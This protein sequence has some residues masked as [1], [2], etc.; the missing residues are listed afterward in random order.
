MVKNVR[1][2]IDEEKFEEAADVILQTLAT[3]INTHAVMISV[4][5]KDLLAIGPALISML[6]GSSESDDE[7]E[8]AE[9]PEKTDA[10]GDDI[11]ITPSTGTLTITY[12]APEGDYD[13]RVPSTIVRNY[14]V[15]QRYKVYANTIRGY[16]VSPKK[17]TG[18]MTADGVTVEFV[19]TKIEDESTETEQ[20]GG[21]TS[22]SGSSS[23]SGG[24]SGSGSGSGSSGSGTGEAGAGSGGASGG[25]SE[26]P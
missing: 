5:K 21:D 14:T 4:T 11:E 25:G 16:T 3:I 10:P 23:G 8:E 12:V 15:G 24:E 19:Y 13:I 9:E 22:G 1:A 7:G 17:A 18:V 20:T 26:L 2:L 6:S